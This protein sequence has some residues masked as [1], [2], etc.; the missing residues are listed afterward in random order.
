V[1]QLEAIRTA[2]KLVDVSPIYVIS[3]ICFHPNC[4]G[5][6]NDD[7]SPEEHF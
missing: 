1:N 7:I 2:K 6:G 5:N 4:V 3:P